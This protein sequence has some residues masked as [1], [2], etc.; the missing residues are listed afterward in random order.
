[1]ISDIGVLRDLRNLTHLSL[2]SNRVVDISAVSGL[3][4]LWIVKLEDNQINNIMPLISNTGIGDGDYFAQEINGQEL[5]WYTV[6]NAGA[7]VEN[8]VYIYIDS[9]SSAFGPDSQLRYDDPIT[10]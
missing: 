3:T 8:R 9:S 7:P 1:M 2:S 6:N 5:E 4:N 10:R